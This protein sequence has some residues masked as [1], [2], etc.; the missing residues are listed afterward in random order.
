MKQSKQNTPFWLKIV[1]SLLMLAV[2]GGAITQ[3]IHNGCVWSKGVCLN[4]WSPDIGW[5]VFPVMFVLLGSGFVKYIQNRN[6]SK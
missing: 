1:V 6:K 4:L 3:Q 5:I 2:L